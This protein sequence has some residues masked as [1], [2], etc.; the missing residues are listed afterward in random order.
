[1]VQVSVN[2]INMIL[3]DYDNMRLM[4]VLLRKRRDAGLPMPK[5]QAQ[6]SDILMKNRDV[7]QN[8]KM[9]RKNKS[10]RR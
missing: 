7:V 5:D 2:D 1:M 3:R 6:L 8:S 10:R 4:S 9:V